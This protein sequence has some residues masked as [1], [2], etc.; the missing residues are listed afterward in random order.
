MA[1]LDADG[2]PGRH[3]AGTLNPL[4]APLYALPRRGSCCTPCRS[5]TCE[6]GR[7]GYGGGA[8]IA[9]ACAVHSTRSMHSCTA[10]PLV[11][12]QSRESPL[13][14]CLHSGFP[15]SSGDP[16]HLPLTSPCPAVAAQAAQPPGPHHRAPGRAGGRGG[17]DGQE[18]CVGAQGRELG[19]PWLL[20]S[21]CL[22]TSAH[23][24][25]AVPTLT[26]PCQVR[27]LDGKSA[28]VEPRTDPNLK[29]NLLYG[30]AWHSGLLWA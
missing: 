11:R 12:A 1:A 13:C 9:C 16:Q 10:R 26:L 20:V 19:H 21:R 3:P 24:S 27:N 7:R 30:L 29:V 18:D 25:A 2:R 8:C 6:Q 15:Q 14:S 22:C 5:W 28:S 23:T 4:P 17:D